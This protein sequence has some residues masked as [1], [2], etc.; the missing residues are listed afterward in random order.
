V[1]LIGEKTR[2]RKSRE[3][4]PLIANLSIYVIKYVYL[5]PVEKMKNQVQREREHP[6]E[7]VKS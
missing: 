1:G 3:T 4:V 2:G 6:G 5:S 7:C